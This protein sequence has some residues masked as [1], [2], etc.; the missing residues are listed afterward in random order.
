MEEFGP[1]V[2][3]VVAI[4]S[5]VLFQTL[6]NFIWFVHHLQDDIWKCSEAHVQ[7][8]SQGPEEWD[9]N[10]IPWSEVIVAWAT[11]L[12]KRHVEWRVAASCGE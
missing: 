12:G 1:I 11:M 4:D 2:L 9:T 8:S 7:C 3:L 6:I 5:E 10:S